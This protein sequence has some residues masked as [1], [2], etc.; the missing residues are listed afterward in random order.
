[1]GHLGGQVGDQLARGLRG[2]AS[3]IERVER[4][5]AQLALAGPVAAPRSVVARRRARSSGAIAA[6][7]GIRFAGQLGRALH[8]AWIVAKI[9]GRG[10]GKLW[11]LL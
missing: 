5:Q 4:E 8:A 1:M 9:M 7:L 3:L 10:N 6:P 2:G 11:W